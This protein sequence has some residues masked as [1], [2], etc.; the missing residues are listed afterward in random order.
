MVFFND[1][2]KKIE[3]Q[4]KVPTLWYQNLII[5]KKLLTDM[6]TLLNYVQSEHNIY[7]EEEIRLAVC[8]VH[9]SNQRVMDI[10]RF[11]LKDTVNDESY[12]SEFRKNIQEELNKIIKMDPYSDDYISVFYQLE[13]QPFAKHEKIKNDCLVLAHYHFI[14]GSLLKDID[15]LISNKTITFSQ[16]KEESTPENA[17]LHIKGIAN[18]IINSASPTSFISLDAF[19]FDKMNHLRHSNRT[20]VEDDINFFNINYEHKNEYVPSYH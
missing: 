5:S 20:Y 17:F 10:I 18:S 13:Q 3:G 2:N 11:N 8:A 6:P 4:S 9:A 7:D 15:T 14:I 1:F 12:I 16:I 19:D